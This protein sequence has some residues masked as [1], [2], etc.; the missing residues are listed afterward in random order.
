MCALLLTLRVIVVMCVFPLTLLVY[1]GDDTRVGGA[2]GRIGCIDTNS[3]PKPTL[4]WQFLLRS[5][6]INRNQKLVTRAKSPYCSSD[7]PTTA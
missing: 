4:Y 1:D 3:S 5:S 7:V 6:R 2:A